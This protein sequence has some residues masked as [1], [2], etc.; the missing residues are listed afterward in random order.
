MNSRASV[1]LLDE[2]DN[3][4]DIPAKRALEAAITASS[5]TIV[6]ISHDRELLSNA[7]S[8]VVTIEATGAWVHGGSYANYEE[9]REH[10]QELLG[11]ALARWQAEE[12]RLFQ[13]YKIMKQRAAQNFK[14][15]TKANAAE[16]RWR[17]FVDAGPPPPPAPRQQVRMRLKG[18]DSARRVLMLEGV[19]L[20]GLIAPFS[21]EIH[22]GERVGLVGPNGSGKSHLLKMLSSELSPDSGSLTTGPRVSTGVFSQINMR[23]DFVGREVLDIVGD[24]LSEEGVAMK[25]LARYGLAGCARHPYQ[26][27]SGGQKARLEILYLELEGHNLLLLDEPTDNLDIDAT[28]ELE[29]ALDAFEGT[30]VAVSHDRTFLSQFDTFLLLDH[31]GDVYELTSYEDALAVLLDPAALKSTKLARPLSVP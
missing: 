16:T 25:A 30:V 10:R 22:F 26:H 9:A 6:F 4:L 20:D 21:I 31:D 3:Y 18:G 8:K 19:G 28:E 24:L 7:A 11:D 5:K 12:R 13:F 1:L 2:P 29:S 15:A 23:E 27:L 17:K 14:N